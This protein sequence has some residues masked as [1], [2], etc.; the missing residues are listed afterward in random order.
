MALGFVRTLNFQES[1][2]AVLD[3]G[4]LD[5]LGGI[6][7]NADILLFDGNTKFVSKLVANEV[8]LANDYSVSNNVVTVTGE[9][10]VAFSDDT[11]ISFQGAPSSFIYTVFNSN[12][13]DKFQI[14]DANGVTQ[15]P[16]GTPPTYGT[17]RRSDHVTQENL[18]NL[19]T[20]RLET[21][22]SIS[23]GISA[24]GD[25][26]GD[27]F[28]QFTSNA[29]VAYIEDKIGLFQYKR[30][31]VPRNYELSTFSVPVKFSGAINI[32]NSVA[33]SSTV[34]S[35]SSPGLFIVDAS[36]PS[37]TAVRAFSDASNPW[38]EVTDALHT[39]EN[40]AQADRLFFDPAGSYAND[41]PNIECVNESGA[42]VTLL[43]TQTNTVS[44]AT[45]KLPVSVNGE[46]FFLL[47]KP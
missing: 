30:S 24:D 45:H 16:S 35:N 39:D 40:N 37:A 14:K 41:T 22:G 38:S 21:N 27:V 32:I 15:S 29:Q 11:K 12:G 31:R 13:V 46:T 17:L 34:P 23:S 33:T 42:G 6:N 43:V 36:N 18:S 44:S 1:N 7:V 20:K 47:L 25:A 5:N 8:G 4:I 10:K 19:S 26:G 9:G 28:N 2:T 3:K